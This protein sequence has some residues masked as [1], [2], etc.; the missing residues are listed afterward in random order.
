MWDE[1]FEKECVEGAKEEIMAA[2]KVAEA[3]PPVGPETMFEDIFMNQTQGL[4]AQKKEL[5]D[6]ML[7]GGVGAEIGHFPL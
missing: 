1:A 5:H 7:K 3:L 6:L 4:K 2:V